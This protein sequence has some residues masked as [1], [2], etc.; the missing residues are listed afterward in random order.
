MSEFVKRCSV[1]SSD[2]FSP[3]YKIEELISF[4]S[5]KAGLGAFICFASVKLQNILFSFSASLSSFTRIFWTSPHDFSSP[6]FAF[7]SARLTCVDKNMYVL[8]TLAVRTLEMQDALG[9]VYISPF[10]SSREATRFSALCE[11]FDS[12]KDHPKRCFEAK[13]T[14]FP[15][16]LWMA[17][18]IQSKHLTDIRE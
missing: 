4:S 1:T 11:N 10:S 7:L 6:S 9:S 3:E 16:K 12:M 8:S 15:S 18:L 14:V 17:S 5:D 2:F 13:E